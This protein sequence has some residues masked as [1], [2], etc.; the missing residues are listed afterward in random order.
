MAAWPKAQVAQTVGVVFVGLEQLRLVEVAR[1]KLITHL[2]GSLEDV[3]HLA[4]KVLGSARGVFRH[5]L[6]TPQ[7]MGQTLLVH[8]ISKALIGRIAI[9]RHGTGPTAADGFFQDFGA[10]AWVDGETGGPIASDP[11]VEP[12]GSAAAFPTRFIG[13]EML[14]IADVLF[15]FLVGGLEAPPR[16]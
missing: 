9:V 14:R 3:D 10:A 12:D 4:G 13:R 11:S 2:Q 5:C 6:R 8:G 15:D 7:R 1:A 16:S